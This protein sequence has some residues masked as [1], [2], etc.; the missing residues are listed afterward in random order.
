MNKQANKKK[1][2]DISKYIDSWLSSG[3]HFV[4]KSFTFREVMSL[5]G[6]WYAMY[7]LDNV[8]VVRFKLGF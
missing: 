1:P 8:F 2:V 4:S 6:N 7:R 3:F 5:N